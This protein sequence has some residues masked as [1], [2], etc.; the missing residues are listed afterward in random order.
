[1]SSMHQYIDDDCETAVAVSVARES[2]IDLAGKYIVFFHDY[3]PQVATL[4]DRFEER[5]SRLARVPFEMMTARG[6]GSCNT[7]I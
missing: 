2:A 7:V 6:I 1:M 3:L 4:M 5:L